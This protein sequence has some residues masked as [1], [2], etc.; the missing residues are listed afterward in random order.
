MFC[1]VILGGYFIVIPALRSDC[2]D[3]I[4]VPQ[5]IISISE[6]ICD[7]LPGIWGLNWVSDRNKQIIEA[8]SI[9][10]INDNE[11]EELEKWVSEEFNIGNYG[12]Q[13]GFSNI[14][15]A[16][17]FADKFLHNLNEY[18]ILSIGLTQSE[19]ELFLS[20]EKPQNNLGGT[21]VYNVLKQ[22]IVLETKAILGV[23]L[24]GYDNGAFHSY[25][26]N[27]LE[28]DLFD[29]YGIIPNKFGFYDDYN[30][31]LEASEYVS[32]DEVGAEPALWQPWIICKEEEVVR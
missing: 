12:W 26:C 16:K 25:L 8:K 17:R 6:C 28:K 23:D 30:C 3:P 11:F 20:K 32:S 1:N 7:V 5:K 29:K 22:G 10:N 4:L 2:M 21:L 15:S 14:I 27:G 9:L 13:H 18:W 24:L 31:I 19:T